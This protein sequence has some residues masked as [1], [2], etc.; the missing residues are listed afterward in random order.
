[1]FGALALNRNR[2]Q[3]RDLSDNLL[4][5]RSRTAWFAR[6][7]GETPQHFAFGRKNG[8]GPARLQPVRQGHISIVVPQRVC[9]D[10][11]DNDGLPEVGGPPAR[12]CLWADGSAVE[13]PGVAGRKAGSRAVP[14]PAAI[15]VQQKDRTKGTA[16]NLLHQPANPVEDRRQSLTL[17]DHFEQPILSGEQRL[18]L[19]QFSQAK[20]TRFK[21]PL[22][23]LHF[24]PK[25][26]DP[27]GIVSLRLEMEIGRSH[28]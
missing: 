19:L 11:T 21:F 16:G 28:V 25:R 9:G 14:K 22:T 26:Y 2:R 23:S 6:E 20:A 7:Y 13:G 4:M 17:R 10:V 3:M 18:S 5:L 1:M 15:R 27:L 24:E 12:T 8:C